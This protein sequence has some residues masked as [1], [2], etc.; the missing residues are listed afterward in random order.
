MFF[1]IPFDLP[2]RFDVQTC[3]KIVPMQIGGFFAVARLFFTDL[4]LIKQCWVF[5]LDTEYRV[6]D[7]SVDRP[8]GNFK[9]WVRTFQ[10]FSITYE[11][12]EQNETHRSSYDVFF[13]GFSV[14]T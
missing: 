7:S 1:G 4:R 11:C 6:Q 5:Q 2:V 10:G 8:S 3:A 9:M 13:Q 12:P 14:V